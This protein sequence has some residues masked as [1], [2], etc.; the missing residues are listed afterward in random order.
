MSPFLKKDHFS[1]EKLQLPLVSS[2]SFTRVSV[3]KKRVV[4]MDGWMIC[5]GEHY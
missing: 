1:S 3:R 2:G 4:Q 5:S